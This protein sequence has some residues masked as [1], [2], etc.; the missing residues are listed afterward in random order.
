MDTTDVRK[1]F[2]QGVEGEQMYQTVWKLRY[3]GILQEDGLG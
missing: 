2:L 1:G 3:K